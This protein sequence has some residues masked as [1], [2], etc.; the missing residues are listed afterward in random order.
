MKNTNRYRTKKRRFTRKSIRKRNNNNKKSSNNNNLNKIYN[1]KYHTK[2][3]NRNYNINKYGGNNSISDPSTL[4]P[5]KQYFITF[6]N[7]EEN[8]EVESE[9][10]PSNNG[11]YIFIS[12]STLYPYY[13]SSS[14]ISYYL[15]ER[16]GQRQPLYLFHDEPITFNDITTYFHVPVTYTDEGTIISEVPRYRWSDDYYH[17][18]RPFRYRCQ[19]SNAYNETD[20]MNVS[21]VSRLKNSNKPL[22][23]EMERSIQSFMIGKDAFHGGRGPFFHNV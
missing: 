1:R 14:I 4:K 17:E 12:K 7:D 21:R 10:A 3:K 13:S 20:L 15:F 6:L 11:L 22:P 2:R 18:N 23:I 5:R 19:I 8:D 9:F 16:N